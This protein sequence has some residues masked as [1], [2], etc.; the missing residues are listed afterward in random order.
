MK[1]AKFDYTDLKGKTKARDVLVVSMPSN[2]LNAI[3]LAEL[4]EEDKAL[5]AVAYSKLMEEHV[6]KIEAL[7]AEFDLK[8]SFR[9]FLESGITNLEVESV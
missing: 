5:F 2:K 8:H 1:L 6:A 4:S 7:K 3:D 9:Q